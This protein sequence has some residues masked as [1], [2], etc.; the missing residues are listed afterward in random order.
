MGSWLLRARLTPPAVEAL[1]GEI[2]RGVG[3]QRFI[4]WAHGILA[5]ICF[6]PISWRFRLQSDKV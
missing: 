4:P 1:E 2:G 6:Y 5:P 3:R